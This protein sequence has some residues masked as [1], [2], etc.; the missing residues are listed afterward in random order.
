MDLGILASGGLNI[1][2]GLIQSAEQRRQR[3][4]IMKRLAEIHLEQ[5]RDF[6]SAKAALTGS[7]LDYTNSPE[8]AAMMKEASGLLT[9]KGPYDDKAVSLLQANA[10]S[11]AGADAALRSSQL[12]EQMAARGLSGSGVAAAAQGSLDAQ[13]SGNMLAERNR[14]GMDAREKQE[15]FRRDALSRA[16]SIFGNDQE[17]RLG[18]GR[19]IAGLYGSKQYGE[20]ALL[21]LA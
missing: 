9:A 17:R 14:I 12:R 7:Q 15:S 20:S 3:R 1:V 11:G 5:R 8:R 6:A 19:D 2:S 13:T 4:K 21:G 10:A 18:F 16:S